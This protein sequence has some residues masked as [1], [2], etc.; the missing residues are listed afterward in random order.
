MSV[1]SEVQL[2]QTSYLYQCQDCYALLYLPLPVLN[3]LRMKPVSLK[4]A[5]NETLKTLKMYDYQLFTK[6]WNISMLNQ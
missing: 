5:V 3:M 2:L 4:L 6:K 1:E